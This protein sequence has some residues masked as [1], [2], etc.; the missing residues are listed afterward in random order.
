MEVVRYYSGCAIER[1]IPWRC[2]ERWFLQVEKRTVYWRSNVY[3]D[4]ESLYSLRSAS[5]EAYR[6]RL[7]STITT[8]ISVLCVLTTLSHD[9]LLEETDDMIA[10]YI[11]RMA[12]ILDVM[13]IIKEFL[14]KAPMWN[15]LLFNRYNET[16]DGTLDALQ[17]VCMAKMGPY[18]KKKEAND[19]VTQTLYSEW[20]NSGA[21]TTLPHCRSS[22]S[23]TK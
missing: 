2:I 3:M 8:S 5:H 22:A 19:N 12:K 17:T 23:S 15:V 1:R 7:V 18:G 4:L 21:G 11:M 20:N 13:D 14:H 10:T 6:L 9:G 16:G